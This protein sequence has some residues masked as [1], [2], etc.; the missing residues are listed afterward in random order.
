MSQQRNTKNLPVPLTDEEYMVRSKELAEQ[1]QALE[2]IESDK[3]VV[4]NQF[5]GEIDAVAAKISHL[6][7]IVKE[8]R[9][10]REVEVNEVRNYDRM[11]MDTVRLDTGEVVSYRDMTS[12][13]RNPSLFAP[14]KERV[15]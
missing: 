5:K 12:Q 7:K 14:D 4:A 6:A 9:E 8:R 10:W 11:T 3:K 2:K 13:E 15:Q 1:V